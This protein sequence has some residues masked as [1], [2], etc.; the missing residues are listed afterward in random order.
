MIQKEERKLWL[1]FLRGFAMLLV[2]WGHVAKT[3]HLFFVVTGSFKMPLFFAITGYVFYCTSV[4]TFFQKL[5]TKIAIPWV[6]LS[7]VW[8]KVF[9]AFITNQPEKISFYLYNFVSG[10]SLWFMPCFII[11]ECIQYII[12]KCVKTNFKQYLAML[13]VS[14]LGI[15]MSKYG[16][17]RFAMFD[18]ACISQAFML[19]GYWFRNNEAI[20][21][22]NIKI[23]R[24]LLMLFIYAALIL[25]SIKFYPG[26]AI[27]VHNNSYYNYMLCGL[28]TFISLLMLFLILQRINLQSYKLFRWIIFV[29]QNTLVFY[30]MHYYPR[31]VINRILPVIIDSFESLNGYI[32][33]FIFIC[34]SMTFITFAIN[35]WF[36]FLVGKKQLL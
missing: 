14:L 23:N 3:E 4:K 32:I 12:R 21:C 7:F 36:P 6:V 5:W 25:I 28:M 33:S 9:F 29:G 20:L 34:V 18:V 27:D 24:L 16:I 26:M 8:V 22:E 1:D 15:V 10:T 19:F 2:I 13:F 35:K 30:I 31:F 17:G 11:A